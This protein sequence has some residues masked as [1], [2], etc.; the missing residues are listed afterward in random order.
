[1]EA[2]AG[3]GVTPDTSPVARGAAAARISPAESSKAAAARI[4]AAESSTT[5]AAAKTAT[6]TKQIAQNHPGKETA[7]PTAAS[8]AAGPHE[9]EQDEQSTQ[10]DGP[11]NG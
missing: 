2:R 4:S 3:R 5:R 9:P 1:M 10:D 7:P 11:R 8:P 6:T